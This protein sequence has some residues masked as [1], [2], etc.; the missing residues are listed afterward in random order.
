MKIRGR[1]GFSVHLALPPEKGTV[2]EAGSLASHWLCLTDELGP[3]REVRQWF[4]AT[5]ADSLLRD[6]EFALAI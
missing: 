3:R 4:R 1:V 2:Y 5:E 6:I